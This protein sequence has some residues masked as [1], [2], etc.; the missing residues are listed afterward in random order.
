MGKKLKKRRQPHGSA[1]HWKQTDCWYYTLP[2]A[3]KRLPLFDEDGER[4]RGKVIE[5]YIETEAAN[6]QVAM[7]SKIFWRVWALFAIPTGVWWA[8]VSFDTAFTFVDWG[9][10]NYP[11]S[12]QSRVDMIFTSIFGSGGVVAGAQAIGSALRRG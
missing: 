9:I 12:V 8:M 10:P 4:I 3:K 6:R 5:K 1:W 7:Q 11:E 2:G